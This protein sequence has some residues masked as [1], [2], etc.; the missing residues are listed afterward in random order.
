V[1]TTFA[2]LTTRGRAFVVA[3]ATA[4]VSAV[5][6]GLD[7]LTRIGALLLLL[8]LL[9]A[10]ALTRGQ[11]RLTLTRTVTPHRLTAGQT[12]TVELDLRNEGRV[13]TGLL[14]LEEQV[15]YALGVRPR[16][17]VDRMGSR[18]HRTV[19][20]VVRSDV[21]GRFTL[22]PM[23]VRVHDPFGLVEL[24]RTFTSTADLVV[25]PKVVPLPAI[26]LEGVWTG[27]GDNRPR[28]FV[29]GSAEDVTVREY[30][31]GDDLRRVHWRSSAHAGEL[32]VRREEQPWQSRATLFVDNRR[33]AHRGTGLSSSFE[34]A[35][36]VAASVGLHLAQRGFRVRLVTAEGHDTDHR[37]HEHAAGTESGPLLESLALLGTVAR[38]TIDTS[39]LNDAHQSS[40]LLVAVLGETL[41]VDRVALSRMRHAAST[42]LAIALDTEQWQ[43]STGPVPRE[44]AALGLLTATGWRS[45]S[46][47]PQEALAGVWQQLGL[48]SRGGRRGSSAAATVDPGA[49]TAVVG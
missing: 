5:A 21:R 10:L 18:W 28:D 43:R 41:P 38:T 29:G 12:A 16:F 13:P 8:P 11:H 3:G 26:P 31:R 46:A 37:W 15:P 47:G 14:L 32:M 4:L 27:S 45:V 44:P 34:Y 23:A 35:V 30:R 1:R 9:T 25:T 36:T 2:S 42:P 49:D 20:Y 24:D 6:V 48:L 19:S 33:H 7:D 39:W 22:G 17:V 40:G